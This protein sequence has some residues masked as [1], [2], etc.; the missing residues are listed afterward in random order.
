MLPASPA[1][2]TRKKDGRFLVE[3]AFGEVAGLDL[4]K[5]EGVELKGLERLFP[6]LENICSSAHAAGSETCEHVFLLSPP[7]VSSPSSVIVSAAPDASRGEAVIVKFS[8]LQPEP[9]SN[10]PSRLPARPALPR[11]RYGMIGTSEAMQNVFRKIELYGPSEAPV[12]ITGETGTGKELTARALHATSSRNGGPFV[13]MNCVALNDELLESELFGH[14]KGAF[15]GAYRSHKGRFERADGGTLFLD[16]IG[17][18]P[19]HLQA[20]LLRVLEDGTMERVGGEKPLKVDV[21][22][23]AA[24]NVPLEAAVSTRRFREDLYH[25]IAVLRIHLPPLR[26]RREDIPLLTAHFLEH[27]NRRYGKKIRRLTADAME[28]LKSY[29]WPGNVRELKNVLERV[30]IETQTEVINARA[31]DE[32]LRE[33]S[34]LSPGG[35]NIRRAR[36]GM[37]RR[38][39]LIP[40]PSGDPAFMTLPGAD[41][42]SAEIRAMQSRPFEEGTTIE[43]EF[44]KLDE[45]TA[46]NAPLP[47]GG[48][49]VPADPS[50]MKQGRSMEEVGVEELVELFRRTGGNLTMVARVLGV[51]KATLYRHLKKLGLTREKLERLAA[52]EGTDGHREPEVTFSA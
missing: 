6:G 14:E 28:L 7:E 24:T 50:P 35:W 32:W 49:P 13:A 21:R 1:L 45:G 41:E 29:A 44:R 37:V 47:D 4:Q 2:V 8:S 20:K 22:L 12:V 27:F 23:V 17:D 42:G 10:R 40:P 19:L 36:H 46:W 31:F 5:F 51:H 25:R 38:R 15:T 52:S 11:G 3:E 26:N 33:R 9:G 43:A 30:Y 16:E 18:M 48:A 39:P 34:M